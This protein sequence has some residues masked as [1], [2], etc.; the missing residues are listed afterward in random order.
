MAAS[1]VYFIMESLPPADSPPLTRK[2]SQSISDIWDLVIK[3]LTAPETPVELVIPM[4]LDHSELICCAYEV[5]E[6]MSFSQR[7]CNSE[8]FSLQTV[9]IIS[10]VF[11][12]ND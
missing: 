9:I 6:A 5:W 3:R 1:D 8:K 11:K 10:R 4:D 2:K 7:D 12:G